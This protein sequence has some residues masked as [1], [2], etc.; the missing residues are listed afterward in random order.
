MKRMQTRESETPILETTSTLTSRV[1]VAKLYK[2][3]LCEYIN[4]A[5]HHRD[6]ELAMTAR[7][8][9]RDSFEK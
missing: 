5:I 4:G 9:S 1:C 7:H 6:K 8:R 3:D 2:I